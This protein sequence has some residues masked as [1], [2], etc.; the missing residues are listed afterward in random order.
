M[1]VFAGSTRVLLDV[2]NEV[3][4]GHKVDSIVQTLES[5]ELDPG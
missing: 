5:L 4:P 3:V 2:Q 1:E